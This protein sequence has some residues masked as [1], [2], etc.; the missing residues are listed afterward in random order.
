MTNDDSFDPLLLDRYLAGELSPTE[1]QRVDA[2]L[3]Q[4]P[5]A[6][7]LLRELP[8][9]SLGAAAHANTDGAWTTLS[10]R[11]ATAGGQDQL[12]ARREQNART[13]ATRR[14]PWLRNAT[15]VAAALI[16]VVG[17]VTTW[18]M[19]RGADAG[20]VTA[21]LGQ[22]VT[23][24]LPDGSTMRLSAGSTARWPS[25]FGKKSRDVMLD[26]E[27]YFDVVH[28]ASRPFRVRAR[29]GIAEDIGTRFVVRAWPEQSA[30][31]VAVEEGAVSLSDT[32]SSTATAPEMLRAG[33]RGSLFDDGRV[34]VTR[35]VESTLAWTKGQLVFDN[36]PL[37]E[38]LPAIG[39]RF[40]VKI[41][42]DSALLNRRLSA[43]FD[44][45]KLSD[46]LSAIALSLNVRV[47]QNDRTITLHQL[48]R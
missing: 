14:S 8:R 44:S 48:A 28:D 20:S 6:A 25:G 35:D 29:G 30:V 16:L 23:A 37:V 18:K 9:A 15:R 27:G 43:R 5:D 39:R 3:A 47:E 40:N 13:T 46:V 4:H 31:E 32:S 22:D 34:E 41:A 38:A 42:S 7:E 1:A 36:M 17:G 11:I 10:S 2:W 45:I 12:A 26:G 24:T 33:Q 21:P 19:T